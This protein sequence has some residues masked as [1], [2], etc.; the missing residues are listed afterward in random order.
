MT[1][2]FNESCLRETDSKENTWEIDRKCG[3]TWG[4]ILEQPY[5]GEPRIARHPF[6][7]SDISSTYL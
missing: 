7:D 3:E 1:A 5:Y 4:Y 2:D 6:S